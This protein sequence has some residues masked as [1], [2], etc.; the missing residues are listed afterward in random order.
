MI[1]KVLKLFICIYLALSGY[2]YAD[3]SDKLYSGNLISITLFGNAQVSKNYRLDPK[4]DIL[5]PD[6][7][8]INCANQTIGT[9]RD[10][11]IKKLGTIFKNA[12]TLSLT[13][14]TNEYYINVLGLVRRAGYHLVPQDASFQ[15]VLQK[16][17]GLSDGAQMNKMQL[18][19]GDQ[20][21]EVNYREF[22]NK[23][24]SK[25]LPTLQ[26]MDEIF[27]PSSKLIS[28]IKTN[29]LSQNNSN[30]DT[31]TT[32][33]DISPVKSVRIIGA[34]NRPGRYVWGDEM[35]LLDILAEAGGPTQSADIASIK[36]T[37]A[38]GPNQ[39]AQAVAFNL[40][41]FMERGGNLKDIPTIKAGYTIE[42]PSLPQP[43][44]N[45]SFKM[46]WLLQNR[47][48]VVYVFGQVKKPGRYS[49]DNKLNFLDILSAADGPTSRA[50][51][52]NIHLID[53]QGVHPQV[54]HV[55]LALYFETGDPEL[56]PPVMTG[57]AV[58]VPELNGDTSE[59]QSKHVVKILGE[60]KTPGRYRYTSNM[61]ILDLLTA[62][63]GPTQEAWVRKILIVNIGPD[64]ESKSSV[65]DLM[66]FSRTGDLRMLPALR[67]GDVI[68]VP[69]NSENDLKKFNDTIQI[70][71]NLA[72]I[73][74]YGSN[75]NG[76]GGR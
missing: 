57:D 60:V 49:F 45:Y 64:M 56:I 7:G 10:L 25:L 18:K 19:R 6:V 5:F 62:A 40:S 34:V 16:A 29:L 21:I 71:A 43:N 4:G 23:G 70:L 27:V 67:E 50:D 46:D 22:L 17:G 69:N 44:V 28:D 42:V 74:S 36:I 12:S 1:N 66:K 55:N 61:T 13:K 3:D 76:N 30:K 73:L 52:H 24:D 38:V 39:K 20:T 63:G 72:L 75:L 51:M 68:Y 8:S 15:V 54:L 31:S 32:W 9:C 47:K 65:F 35:S 11:A 26:P 48:T 59:V 53:R 41:E 58:Y 33:L 14:K 2:A 37:S